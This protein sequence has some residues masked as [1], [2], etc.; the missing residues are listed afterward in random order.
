MSRDELANE[1]LGEFAKYFS[2]EL[3]PKLG[4]YPL[5]TAH[6][7]YQNNPMIRA[8]ADSFTCSV[9]Q[10]VDKHVVFNAPTQPTRECSQSPRND[11][12]HEWV[13][14]A[15]QDSETD[16]ATVKTYCKNCGEAQQ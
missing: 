5:S 3:L 2:H 16:T 9:M 8:K 6:R 7:L 13:S 1:L 12:G 10:I 14:Q 15:H 11:G 4:E